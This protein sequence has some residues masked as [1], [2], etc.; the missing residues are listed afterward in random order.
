LRI[1]NGFGVYYFKKCSTLISKECLHQK[2]IL[3]KILDN[4]QVGLEHVKEV[5]TLKHRMGLE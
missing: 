2:E 3:N 5:D 4:K 1:I